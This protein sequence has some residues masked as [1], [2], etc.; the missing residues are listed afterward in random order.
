LSRKTKIAL[1][2][3][4]PILYRNWTKSIREVKAKPVRGNLELSF[5]NYFGLS[6]T[7]RSLKSHRRKGELN[8]TMRTNQLGRHFFPPSVETVPVDERKLKRMREVG[9]VLPGYRPDHLRLSP[10]PKK[11]SKD[12]EVKPAWRRR[13]GRRDNLGEPGTIFPPDTRYVFSDTSFPYSTCGLVQTASGWASGVMIGPRHMMTASHAINWGNNNSAGWVKFIPMNFDTSEPFGSAFATRI[14]WWQ[15]VNGSDGVSSNE[16]AFDYVVCTLDRR[17]GDITG[18][19]GSRPYSPSWNGGAY[20][21]HIGY[22]S[23][24]GAGV[25][26]VFHADGVMDTTISESS[27]GRNSFRIMHRNDYWFGQSGGPTYGWWSGEEWPRAVAIYSAVNWGGT[28]GPNANGGGDPLPVLINH[29][30]TAEP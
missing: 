18:F 12:L 13:E 9:D 22:P 19:M 2:D 24:L 5:G 28:G 8:V 30:R 11:L 21:A 16:A 25:R 23:D 7:V 10:I 15:R 14:Y 20:W 4:A 1:S 27:S 26:P 17:L 3:T 6:D 29:A